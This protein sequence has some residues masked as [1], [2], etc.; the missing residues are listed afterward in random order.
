MD[1]Q[2]GLIL[3]I[4]HQLDRITSSRS[5][6]KLQEHHLGRISFSLSLKVQAIYLCIFIKKFMLQLFVCFFFQCQNEQ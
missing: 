5:H 3:P 1:R 2:A 4:K 6:L